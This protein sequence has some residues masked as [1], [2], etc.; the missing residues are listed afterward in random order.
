MK[1][2]QVGIAVTTEDER[3]RRE[4]RKAK[5]KAEELARELAAKRAADPV[6]ASIDA[7]AAQVVNP[8][9]KNGGKA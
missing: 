7:Q 5:K 6:L 1:S 9:V 8:R 2:T 4:E 3:K